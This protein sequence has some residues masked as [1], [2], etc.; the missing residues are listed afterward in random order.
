MEQVARRVLIILS[1]TISASCLRLDRIDRRRRGSLSFD[2][3]ASYC[4]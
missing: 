3:Y 4:D 2:D 1:S